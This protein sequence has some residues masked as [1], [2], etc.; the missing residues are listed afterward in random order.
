MK[1]FFL[2]AGGFF[3]NLFAKIVDVLNRAEQK[4]FDFLYAKLSVTPFSELTEDIIFYSALAVAALLIILI[5]VLIFKPKKRKY[6]FIIENDKIVRKFKKK[7]DIPY[8]EVA[9]ADDEIMAGWFSDSNYNNL[10]DLTNAKKRKLKLYAKIVKADSMLTGTPVAEQA[11]NV[12]AESL[13]K[14]VA[15]PA[16]VQSDASAAQ[17]FC[18]ECGAKLSPDAAFCVN[19]GAKIGYRAAAA[20]APAYV[21]P[22][23][24][25]PT[26]VQ[27]AAEAPAQPTPAQPTYEWKAEAERP[28][29]P[30]VQQ[31]APAYEK[32]AEGKTEPKR[33]VD[34]GGLV[35]EAP[36][37]K[38]NIV[39]ERLEITR[40]ALTLGEI[41]DEIRFELLS[42]ERAKAFN[43][44]GTARKKFIAEMFEKD[45]VVY[46]YLAVDPDVMIEKGYRVEKHN[47]PEFKVVPAKKTITG[48]KDYQEVMALIKETMT[49]NNL[50]KSE[51]NMATKTVSDETARRN[52]FAFFVKN[53]V[54]ATAAQDYYKLLRANVLSYSVDKSKPFNEANSGKMILKIFKKGEKIF[55]Y[56]TLDAAAENLEFVGY[57]KNFADTPAMF[58]VATLDD[59]NRAYALIEKVMF[60]FGMEKHPENAELLLD[61]SLK[62]NCGFGYR[63]RN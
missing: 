1:E 48:A 11:S 51:V 49:F 16:P 61:E 55:V 17:R 43:K 29:E 8:P 3:K 41:Y 50:V 14:T 42:Y 62:E 47:D 56:L 30:V 28:V 34:F 2:K 35:E 58:E 60:R 6:T 9:L 18:P 12:A 31:V 20:E 52:G 38:P 46:L 27:P 23:A 32:S 40:P 53:D 22:A 63:I 24:E 57:D 36:S 37:V 7:E 26:Y 15:A 10:F 59:L 25:A 21:Q 45:G 33:D 54:V 39:E 13:D 44:L 5:L 19:C 4:A